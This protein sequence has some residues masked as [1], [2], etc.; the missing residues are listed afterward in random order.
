MKLDSLDDKKK[1]FIWLLITIVW[2]I[3]PI[4]DTIESFLG[5]FCL[6]DEVLLTVVTCYKGF[7]TFLKTNTESG[8]KYYGKKLSH[9]VVKDPKIV[10]SVDATIDTI[11]ASKSEQM[12]NS[13]PL[14]REKSVNNMGNMDLFK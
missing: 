3:S 6:T 10:N 7:R 13:E 8:A 11:V 5:P 2:W 9:S 4:D 12:G 14:K 1:F